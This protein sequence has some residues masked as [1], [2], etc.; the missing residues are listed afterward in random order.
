MSID[1]KWLEENILKRPM[2]ENEQQALQCLRV[3]EYKSGDTIVEQGKP[4]GQLYILR[5]GKASV[6]DNNAET[7]RVRIASVDAGAMFGE[8]T[9]MN[10]T[11]TTAEV[12]A[13][14]DCVVYK[15]S[16]DDFAKVMHERE[17]GFAIFSAMLENQGNIIRTMNA[18]MTPVLQKLA[19]KAASLPTFVKV[20][21]ILFIL[22]YLSAFI[23]ISFKDF[24]Y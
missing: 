13:R 4:G 6:E 7:G 3:R 15:L 5:S 12:V 14:E 16:R 1:I 23:Y 21:A 22:A 11:P 9:F 8:L 19:K 20:F 24:A 2:N 10:N 18:Q 17:V